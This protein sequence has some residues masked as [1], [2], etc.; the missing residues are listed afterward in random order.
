MCLAIPGKI[1][2]IDGDQGKV[3]FGGVIRTTNISMI[4]AEVGKWAVVHAGFA[5]EVMDEDEARETM[6]LWNA[7]ID[8]GCLEEHHPE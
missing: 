4:D 1:V 6:D 7:V 2:G 3:D 5:I 8:S